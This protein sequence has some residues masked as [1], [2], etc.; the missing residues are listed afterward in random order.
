M[1]IDFA[2]VFEEGDIEGYRLVCC[3]TDKEL[4]QVDSYREAKRVSDLHAVLC[5]ECGYLDG[6]YIYEITD[7]PR[8]NVSSANGAALLEVLGL[9]LQDTEVIDGLWYCVQD[10][11]LD[12]KAFLGRVLLAQG[13]APADAGIPWHDISR[14]GGPMVIQCGRREGYIDEKLI[15]LEVLARWAMEHGRKVQWT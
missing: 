12:A 7:V 5:E 6:C 8:L 10:G 15:E 3:L 1:S 14:P 4:V 11:V 9:R 13:V 2:P